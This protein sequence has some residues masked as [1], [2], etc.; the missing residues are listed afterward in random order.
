MGFQPTTLR[1]LDLKDGGS[2]V[3][4]PSEAPMFSVSS[5]GRF[6][7]SPFISFII[8]MRYRAKYYTIV[9]KKIYVRENVELYG[10]PQGT[11]CKFKK[12][13]CK[14]IKVA[15]N[16]KKAAANLKKLL[17]IYKGCCKFINVAANLQ[18]LL[19]IYKGCCKFIKA[20]ANL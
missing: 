6:F 14:F 16:L 10:G 17:Q 20:A 18:M 13:C 7:T 5:Y 19:Q 2:S 12:G 15:A 4:I 11:F 1:V 9:K 8:L 3:R